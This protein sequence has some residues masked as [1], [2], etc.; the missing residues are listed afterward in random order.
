[1][2]L[3]DHIDHLG[4]LRNDQN[5]GMSLYDLFTK[6]FLNSLLPLKNKRLRQIKDKFLSLN[7]VYRCSP[8]P[9]VLSWYL[10]V[11][12]E[13]FSGIGWLSSLGLDRMIRKLTPQ[14][15]TDTSFQSAYK[16]GII[17]LPVSYL[18]IKDQNMG[19]NY[20]FLVDLHGRETSLFK[21]MLNI[22]VRQLWF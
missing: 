16:L 17:C 3:L 14:T 6:H 19:W 8:S 13:L 4:L 7:I 20:N 10:Y 15:W 18:Q 21:P 9:I 12:C 1:M 11:C 2:I 22:L 5:D